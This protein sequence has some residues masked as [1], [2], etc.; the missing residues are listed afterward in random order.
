MSLF[1]GREGHRTRSKQASGGRSW[2]SSPHRKAVTIS[3][4]FG[5]KA[6][7]PEAEVWAVIDAEARLM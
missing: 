1:R 7:I 5:D 3:A 2:F 4:A 6:N